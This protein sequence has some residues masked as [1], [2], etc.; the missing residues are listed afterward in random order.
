MRSRQVSRANHS[1]SAARNARV[2]HSPSPPESARVVLL[3]MTS[4]RGEELY[5]WLDE[6][7]A[8]LG[9]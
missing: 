4:A 7:I 6:Q 9:S 1:A 8:A 3:S 2:I 5:P